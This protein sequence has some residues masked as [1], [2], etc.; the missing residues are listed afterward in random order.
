MCPA[1]PLPGSPA[2]SLLPCVHPLLPGE[3]RTHPVPGLRASPPRPSQVLSSATAG[4]W[5]LSPAE[6]LDFPG[7]LDRCPLLRLP[8]IKP[9]ALGP[10][11]PLGGPLGMWLHRAWGC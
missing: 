5:R 7:L 8:H 3:P 4:Q 10:V 2:P 6:P 1:P 9:T 11:H